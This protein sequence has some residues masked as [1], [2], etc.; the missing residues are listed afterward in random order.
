MT[1]IS[2][3]K[4]DSAAMKGRHRT[5]SDQSAGHSLIRHARGH[6]REAQ[7]EFD[8]INRPNK[9]HHGEKGHL[10]C[11]RTHPPCLVHETLMAVILSSIIL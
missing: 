11:S 2:E 3:L 8:K 9:D 1:W 5:L 6:N 4:S 7:D 10:G